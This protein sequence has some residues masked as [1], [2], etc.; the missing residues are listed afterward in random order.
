M[1]LIELL[2]GKKDF[3]TRSASS[4]LIPFS[5]Q[6]SFEIDARELLISGRTSVVLSMGFCDVN[7]FRFLV[8][9]VSVH[10]CA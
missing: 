3:V 5:P 10:C 8:P 4:S 6:M 7:S 2:M 9:L 1:D